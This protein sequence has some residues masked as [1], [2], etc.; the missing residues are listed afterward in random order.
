M[1]VPEGSDRAG[2]P[3]RGASLLGLIIVPIVL[4]RRLPLQNNMLDTTKKYL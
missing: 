1:L 4:I 3:P 2:P